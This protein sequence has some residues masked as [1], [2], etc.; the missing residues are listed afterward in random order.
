LG[1]TVAEKYELEKGSLVICARLGV[2]KK[3]KANIGGGIG[4]I[5]AVK[6]ALEEV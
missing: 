4:G 1:A 2:R 5:V 3:S 6:I